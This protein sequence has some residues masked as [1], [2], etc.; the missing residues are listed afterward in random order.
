[1]LDLAKYHIEKSSGIPFYLQLKNQIEHYILTNVLL[2]D[3]RLPSIHF[4]AKELSVNIE[5]IRKAYKVLEQE[6]LLAM[7]RAKGTCV[8]QNKRSPLVLPICVERAGECSNFKNIILCLIKDG[9]SENEIRIKFNEDM[10]DIVIER[11]KRFIIFA[12]CNLFPIEKVSSEL[13]KTLKLK[14]VPAD[15]SKLKSKLNRINTEKKTLSA[16]LT[17]NFHIDEVRKAA[18]GLSVECFALRMCISQQSQRVIDEMGA[19][20]K[21]VFIG[22]NKESLPDYKNLIKN[23][24]GKKFKL[25]T[26]YM[27]DKTG[28]ESAIRSAAILLVPPY[29]YDEIKAR[30]P[31]NQLIISLFNQIDPM[32]IRNLKDKIF[33]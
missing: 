15:I 5:T 31:E 21:Y 27:G 4:L 25:S 13:E 3:Q 8:A 22:R 23:H 33:S 19:K 12:E 20:K 28:I 1:M 29:L 7:R 26:T 9:V 10:K 18:E 14:V 32:A 11:R 17:T 24:L 16:I 6:G 30:V 2:P